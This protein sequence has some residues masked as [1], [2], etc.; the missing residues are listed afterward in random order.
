MILLLSSSRLNNYSWTGR[1]EDGEKKIPQNMGIT[2]PKIQ[3]HIPELLNLQ[4]NCYENLK[5][6]RSRPLLHTS[7]TLEDLWG[8]GGRRYKSTHYSSRHSVEM[9]ESDVSPFRV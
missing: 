3:F 4:Q 6:H 9:T 5:P 7:T 8:G 1:P 2:N